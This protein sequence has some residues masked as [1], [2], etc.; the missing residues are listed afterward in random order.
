MSFSPS[1]V[2]RLASVAMPSPH[3]HRHLLPSMAR[4]G[5]GCC[6]PRRSMG[7]MRAWDVLV[8]AVLV[9]AIW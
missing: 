8:C 5:E 6:S 4:K 9:L 1:L 7:R 2:Q 3:R